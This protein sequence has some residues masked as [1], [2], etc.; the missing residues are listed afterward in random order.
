MIKR[1]LISDGLLSLAC[2]HTHK[3]FVSLIIH[4][5]KSYM[6]MLI[7]H[8]VLPIAYLMHWSH[9]SACCLICFFPFVWQQGCCTSVKIVKSFDADP[10]ILLVLTPNYL[11]N[12]VLLLLLLVCFIL[13]LFNSWSKSHLPEDE[14]LKSPSSWTQPA[15][16]F[17]IE[18]VF[19]WYDASKF[20]EFR[21]GSLIYSVALVL[22]G[23]E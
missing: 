16:V 6:L 23:F 7:M 5:E 14:E 10:Q 11:Y 15:C 22:S 12:A 19:A 17:L 2:A 8:H 21:C 9:T 18:K 4:C 3:H 1:R 20:L 13:G